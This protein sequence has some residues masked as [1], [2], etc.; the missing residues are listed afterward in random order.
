MISTAHKR[1][2]ILVHGVKNRVFENVYT[3][4]CDPFGCWN[5]RL[6]LSSWVV[7]WE[8]QHFCVLV[9]Q[10]RK[11]DDNISVVLLPIP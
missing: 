2:V 3:L 11:A 6:T 5:L 9:A 8:T 1:R 4:A 7:F 10:E